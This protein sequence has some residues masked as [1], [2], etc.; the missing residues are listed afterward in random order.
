M[1]WVL[2]IDRSGQG[3]RYVRSYDSRADAELALL[4][5]ID[6]APELKDDIYVIHAGF[7]ALEPVTN[8]RTQ[9]SSQGPQG[10]TVP[11]SEP[12]VSTTRTGL[13]VT[14]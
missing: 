5:L 6:D 1:S 7:A 12:S 10:V 4:E 2:V 8:D 13:N 14:G 3:P 11:D 9:S